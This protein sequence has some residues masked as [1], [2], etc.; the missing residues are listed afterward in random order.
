MY[1]K[2]CHLKIKLEFQSI[3]W[4]LNTEMIFECCRCNWPTVKF[5][6]RVWFD[7]FWQ[8]YALIYPSRKHQQ[9][10]IRNISQSLE[11]SSCS[12]LANS[13]LPRTPS[14][15][16]TLLTSITTDNFACSRMRRSEIL[17]YGLVLSLSLMFFKFIHV[18]CVTSSFLS[19]AED[20][21]VGWICHNLFIFRLIGI[22]L[23]PVSGY[24]E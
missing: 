13:Y 1:C 9:N 3:W 19:I 18:V 7:V 6:L 21:S 11:T 23:F 17:E 24:Y 15:N 12:I 5:I 8:L 20:Y 16:E 14:L 10:K 2:C 22:G 4:N